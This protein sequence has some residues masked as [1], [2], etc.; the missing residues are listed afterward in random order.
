[1]LSHCLRIFPEPLTLNLGG[2]F[3]GDIAG[4]WRALDEDLSGYITLQE[5]LGLTP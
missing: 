3:G 5:G 4:A 2:V 1:M